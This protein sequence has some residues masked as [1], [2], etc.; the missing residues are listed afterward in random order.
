M[1]HAL[2]LAHASTG[3]PSVKRNQLQRHANGWYKP[4]TDDINGV[5]SLYTH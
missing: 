2:G 4:Q 5:N 3:V 1:G